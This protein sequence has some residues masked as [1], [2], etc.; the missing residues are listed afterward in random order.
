MKK[1]LLVLSL[2]MLL[3]IICG[4]VKDKDNQ[5]EEKQLDEPTINEVVQESE[6]EII[7]YWSSVD[8][9][10]KYVISINGRET[11]VAD[12]YFNI[13]N[14]IKKTCTVEIKVKARADG[15]LDS[16]WSISYFY[17][18]EYEDDQNNNN[19]QDD[20]NEN[21]NDKEELIPLSTPKKVSYDEESHKI[22]WDYVDNAYKYEVVINSKKYETYDL[23]FEVEFTAEQ[24][25]VYKVRAI[26]DGIE[27]SSSDYSELAK[28]NYIIKSNNNNDNEVNSEYY[29][30]YLK[31]QLGFGINIITAEY[32]DSQAI[33]NSTFLDIEKLS[34]MYKLLSS[35][36]KDTT[37]KTIEESSYESFA[38]DVANKYTFG[39]SANFGVDAGLFGFSA[40]LSQKIDVS[41]NF[42]MSSKTKQ[43][44]NLG[45]QNMIDKEWAIMNFDANEIKEKNIL[46]SYALNELSAILAEEDINKQEQLILKFFDVFGTHIITDALYGGK[47]EVLFYLLS[48]DES[49]DYSL[50]T[51]YNT[52]LKTSGEYGS[53]EG[54]AETSIGISNA[55]STSIATGKTISQFSARFIGGGAVGMSGTSDMTKFYENCNAW[56]DEYNA[57][58]YKNT[59]IALNNGGLCPIWDLLPSAYEGLKEVMKNTFNKRLALVNEEFINKEF[60]YEIDKTKEFSGGCGTKED[61]Y[62]I[63]NEHQLVLINDYLGKENVWF[64][65]VNDIT[66]T[67]DRWQPIGKKTAT[68]KQHDKK[69][70]DLKTEEAI[71]N[72][73]MGCLDGNNKT[74]KY[75]LNMDMFITENGKD[76]S[77][78][79]FALLNNAK[80]INLNVYGEVYGTVIT[81]GDANVVGLISGWA[82]NTEFTNCTTSGKITQDCCG[83]QNYAWVNSGG[84]VGTAIEC[85]F[86][87]CTNNADVFTKTMYVSSAGLVASGWNC[88]VSECVNTGQINAE[89]SG[90]FLGA[91]RVRIND[92][93]Y[94]E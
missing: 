64:K 69:F 52:S 67:G 6:K 17:D 82:I 59:M 27:Y 8:N 22:T 66:I 10:E 49:F 53:Y 41:S 88:R 39:A 94:N 15:Y 55:L 35:S 91:G 1:I 28:A 71:K 37:F 18:V 74:I 42:K 40:T 43:Y 13:C 14:I 31:Y 46:T 48:N 5:N 50:T 26:G 58:S 9:A 84:F 61:P 79:L 62:L 89:K 47:V 92:L 34:K 86:T 38:L 73:F 36:V 45:Y 81:R 16:D 80:I 83:G 4:C 12:N 29:E 23:A 65:L 68:S 77:F 70:S 2:F 72:S 24:E 32:L 19:N 33:T 3:V 21:N 63:E 44:Y 54:S 30:D 25:F 76:Y 7:A 85:I 51:D 57:L 11:A 20:N 90:G 56:I 78:G 75:E 60:N 87:K 93:I